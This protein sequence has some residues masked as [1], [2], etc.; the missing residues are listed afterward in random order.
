MID[1]KPCPFC[2]GAPA[3]RMERETA[4]HGDVMSVAM[5]SCA[6]CFASTR[7]ADRMFMGRQ[8]EIERKAVECAVERWNRR[9]E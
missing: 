6:N 8:E 1:L 3:L 5:V 2:G 9:T 7:A 4:G